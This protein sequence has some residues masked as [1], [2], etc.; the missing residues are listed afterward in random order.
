MIAANGLTGGRIGDATLEALH[1]RPAVLGRFS[2]DA[3]WNLIN[4]DD[5]DDIVLLQSHGQRPLALEAIGAIV[6]EGHRGSLG[7]HDLEFYAGHADGGRR[8]DLSLGCLFSIIPR[9]APV[10]TFV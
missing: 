6:N 7:V 1:H 2:G 10:S 8:F 5:V 4:N 3:G 9:T